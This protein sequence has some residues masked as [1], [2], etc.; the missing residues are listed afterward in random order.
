MLFFAFFV[1]EVRTLGLFLLALLMLAGLVVIQRTALKI[2][3]RANAHR[4]NGDPA[5][6][7]APTR[8]A[9]GRR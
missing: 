9:A 1:S 4:R 2:V 7:D 3:H 6:S 5:L 8:T